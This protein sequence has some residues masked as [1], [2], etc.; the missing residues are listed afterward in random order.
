MG[1]T[2]HRC[3]P[4]SRTRCSARQRIRSPEQSRNATGV[5]IEDNVAATAYGRGVQPR[6]DLGGGRDVQ[7]AVER[8]DGTPVHLTRA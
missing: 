2:R 6:H 7:L 3:P 8:D 5:E 1:Q 4:R